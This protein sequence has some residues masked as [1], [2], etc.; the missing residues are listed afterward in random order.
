ML[1]NNP[2]YAGSSNPS[3]LILGFSK[4]ANQ[5]QIAKQGNYD[6]VPFAGMRD[7]LQQV[8]ATLDLMPT[9]RDIDQ[10]L[11]ANERE[12]GAASLVRC[13][14][15]RKK[16]DNCITSGTLVTDGFNIPEIKAIIEQ[17]A[18][19]FLSKPPESL[20]R[21]ILLG[22]NRIYIKETMGLFQHLYPDFSCI[23]EVAFQARGV[24]WIYVAH[25][26]KANGRFKAWIDAEPGSL[27]GQKCLLAREA[28]AAHR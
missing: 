7:R 23:N 12:F 27:T 14:L 11:T 25:P 6:Q 13:S 15:C 20:R 10:M 24:L 3:T 26:S 18:T 21:V 1:Y 4:G 19:T 17:C 16:G 8:L 9:D 22:T 28:F 5:N 2:G